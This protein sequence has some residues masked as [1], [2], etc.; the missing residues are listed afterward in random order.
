MSNSTQSVPHTRD[1][2]IWLAI[3]A[4]LLSLFVACA[5]LAQQ[6]LAAFQERL[7]PILEGRIGG[8]LD[9]RSVSFSGVKGFRLDEPSFRLKVYDSPLNLVATAPAAYVHFNLADLL[10]GAVTI[11]RIEMRY[12]AVH[13]DCQGKTLHEVIDLLRKGPALSSAAKTF[14]F[15][16]DGGQFSLV[17]LSGNRTLTLQDVQFDIHR[18]PPSSEFRVAVTGRGDAAGRPV[19]NAEAT[20]RP[21]NDFSARIEVAGLTA[22]TAA[23]V[24]P[25]C[26]EIIEKGVFDV[27]LRLEGYL[28][29]PMDIAVET[30]FD[31][32]ALRNKTYPFG[33]STG[34]FTA[35]ASYDRASGEVTFSSAQIRTEALSGNIRGTIIL[36]QE[37]PILDITIETDDLP[38]QP[39]VRDWIAD[40][41]QPY[42]T[43]LVDVEPVGRVEV[44]V[45]GPASKPAISVAARR[46][47]GRIAFSPNAPDYPSADLAFSL[48][49]AHWDSVV[50]EP[51]A[52]LHITRG[53]LDF[54]RGGIRA[55]NLTGV[56]IVY[57]TRILL[58][59]LAAEITSSRTVA[60]A[61]FDWETQQGWATVRGTLNNIENTV[62]TDTI[63]NVILT[64]SASVDAHISY[65]N[66]VVAMEGD[67]DITH[68]SLAYRWWFLK[69]VGIGARAH[70]TGEWKPRKSCLFQGSIEALG[71]RGVFDSTLEYKAGKYRLKSAHATFET[72]DVATVGQCLRIPYQVAGGAA[73]Q[74][75]YEWLRE[76]DTAPDAPPFWHAAASCTIDDLVILAQG[77]DV[78]VQLK[79]VSVEAKFDNAEDKSAAISVVS[80]TCHMPPF[81]SVWF[82]TLDVPP[83]LKD[84]YR[85]DEREYSFSL[86]AG[87]IAVPPWKG[88]NFKG[89]AFYSPTSFGLSSYSAEID[90]GH[91]QGSYVKHRADNAFEASARWDNMPA[92][93]LIRHLRMPEFLR[94]TTTGEV[95]Y[96][97]DYDDP[98]TLHGKGEF[99]VASGQFSADFLL[100][101]LG[102][103]GFNES[104]TSL[105]P[106]LLFDQ[107][108]VEVE[109][110]RDWVRTPAIKLISEGI[111]VAARGRFVIRGDMEYDLTVSLSPETADR[112]PALKQHLN[113]EGHRLAGQNIELAFRLSGPTY[114]PRGE[115]SQSPPVSVTLMTGG[116][117]MVSE[118]VRVID[119]PRKIL[120]DLLRIGGGIIGGGKRQ[121]QEP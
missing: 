68:T 62:L 43:A 35:W 2:R 118:A 72:L 102:L 103:E 12:A 113:I 61:E 117:E 3:F 50:R 52:T 79:N 87:H 108:R 38:V 16:G 99:E 34:T 112:I 7:L 36:A 19:V 47:T 76:A 30:S 29:N 81:G 84:R 75:T 70:V 40:R 46:T 115:L 10:F 56:L 63:K 60:S 65:A 41:I 22:E 67:L 37:D 104:S 90:D 93:Y 5:L 32:V 107:L 71:T 121:T 111:D 59:P 9:I 89:S 101:E 77:A 82:A 24:A 15:L 51:A 33:S 78:P 95:A 69:P 14:R 55:E 25:R 28:D 119:I 1:L 88:S 64:G 110:E 91:I 4:V 20:V 92:T 18:L 13:L 49:E 98:G 11:D 109:F 58:N 120:A 21:S 57:G 31:G 23:V 8:Q 94:G 27:R 6:R 83:E 48:V 66:N 73:R 116:L 106:S 96:S 54:A 80:E 114:K 74:G 17:N 39:F 86:E 42:G 97:M 105:P 45:R 100:F 26:A 44:C 85:P 53:N